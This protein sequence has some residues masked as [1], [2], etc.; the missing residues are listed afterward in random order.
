M[1][2]FGRGLN[3]GS[4]EAEE[5]EVN[6]KMD[7]LESRVACRGGGVCRQTLST[8]EAEL[9]LAGQRGGVGSGRYGRTSAGCTKVRWG[10]GILGRGRGVVGILL[11]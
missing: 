8:E 11:D 9:E 2:S 6:E 4:D 7:E 1:R 5:S 3:S 10:G